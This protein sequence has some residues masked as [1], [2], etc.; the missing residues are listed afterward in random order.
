MCM[1]EMWSVRAKVSITLSQI[2]VVAIDR[3]KLQEPLYAFSCFRTV[4]A[5]QVLFLRIAGD[6]LSRIHDK[7]PM[8]RLADTHLSW[9]HKDMEKSKHGH[10]SYAPQHPGTAR[11]YVFTA[12]GWRLR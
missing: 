4:R 8:G 10:T 12:C 2:R 1:C 5:T 6:P 7:R 3:V 9:S 11:R